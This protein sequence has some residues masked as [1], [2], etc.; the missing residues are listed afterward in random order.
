MKRNA[1]SIDGQWAHGEAGRTADVV[2]PANDAIIGT[3]PNAVGRRRA[4]PLQ[5]P[6]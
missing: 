5:Q 1:L 6:S 4:G 2:N 3:V